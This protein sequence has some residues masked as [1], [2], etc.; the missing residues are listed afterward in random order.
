MK[1]LRKKYIVVFLIKEQN[2]YS[3]VSRKL[4][5]STTTK[6]KFGKK[7]TIPID[8]SKPSYSK[9]LKLFYFID[10]S[11]NLQLHFIKDKNN[12]INSE[13][14]DMI[15]QQEIIRQLTS[16]LGEPSFLAGK[17]F[18]MIVGG[19]IGLLIGF[20]IASYL[21]KYGVGL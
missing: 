15:F 9:G 11:N 18:N 3:E 17:L 16:S 21:A 2:S 12:R 13:A 19:I 1:I 7:D 5:K 6:I 10:L 8:I 4:V 20:V 14:M